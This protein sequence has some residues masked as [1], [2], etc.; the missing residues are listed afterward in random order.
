MVT[1]RN[2]WLRSMPGGDLVTIRNAWLRSMPGGDLVTKECLVMF[3]VPS[4][5]CANVP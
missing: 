4:L 2:A 1:I 3:Q 5:A